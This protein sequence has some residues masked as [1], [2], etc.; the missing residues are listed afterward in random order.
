[1][2]AVSLRL[3]FI[4]QGNSL[5]TITFPESKTFLFGETFT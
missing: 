4:N 5:A 2:I 3:C 1:M